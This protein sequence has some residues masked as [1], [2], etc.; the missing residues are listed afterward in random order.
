MQVR[1]QRKESRVGGT[2]HLILEVG[3]ALRRLRVRAW[4]P[5]ASCQLAAK[6]H[7]DLG[8]MSPCHPGMRFPSNGHSEARHMHTL[9]RN[10]DVQA[11]AL[12]PPLAR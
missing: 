8:I 1:F 3:L 10:V 6:P 11:P 7:R 5:S 9:T 4:Q 12:Q 2:G